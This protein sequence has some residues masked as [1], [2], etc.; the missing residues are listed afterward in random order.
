VTPTAPT[1]TDKVGTAD[2]SYTVP[3]KAGVEY[4]VGGVVTAAGTY[5]GRGSVT[6]TAGAKP[7][8]VLA[9]TTT[10]TFQFTDVVPPTP[11]PSPSVT[12][13]GVVASA[14][15][16]GQTALNPGFGAKTG[17]VAPISTWNGS[18]L[19]GVLLLTIAGLSGLAFYLRRRTGEQ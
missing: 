10:W 11:T 1:F 9:G 2:D 12:V 4:S 7:G 13:A 8:Y 18:A 16:G 19:G 14:S 3:S 17:W 6:V 15:S 5:P